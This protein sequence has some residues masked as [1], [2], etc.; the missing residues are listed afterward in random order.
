MYLGTALLAMDLVFIRIHPIYGFHVIARI[1]PTNKSMK[2]MKDPLNKSINN[3]Y[4]EYEAYEGPIDK[5]ETYYE[6]TYYGQNE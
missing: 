2:P 4:Q 6:E 1:E 3:K 5:E